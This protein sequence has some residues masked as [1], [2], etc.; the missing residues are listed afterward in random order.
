ML[1]RYSK[2]VIIYSNIKA[3][4]IKRKWDICQWAFL[5]S[6]KVLELTSLQY[7]D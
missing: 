3:S 6:L 4:V 5:V 1:Y 2:A 7:Y